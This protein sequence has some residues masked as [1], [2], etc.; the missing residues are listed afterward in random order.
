M[1][2]YSNPNECECCRRRDG[3]GFRALVWHV[4][5][6]KKYIAR[7]E[8]PHTTTMDVFLCDKCADANQ[9]NELYG[10]DEFDAMD[11]LQSPR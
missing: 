3:T 1:F 6:R 2:T 7:G 10:W 9:N 4:R 11:G 8:F 5:P